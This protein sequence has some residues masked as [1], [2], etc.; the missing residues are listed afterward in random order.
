MTAIELK[1]FVHKF[2]MMNP[3]L[4]ELLSSG[5][6]LEDGMMVLIEDSRERVNITDDFFEKAPRWLLSRALEANRWC[7]VQDAQVIGDNVWFTGVYEDGTKQRRRCEV[8][9]A[10]LVTKVSMPKPAESQEDKYT[11][12]LT[13]VAKTMLAQDAATYH[14]D[15]TGMDKV[16]DEAAKKIMELFA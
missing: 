6:L 4:E 11:Q 9:K 10:W 3:F 12:V 16:A 15:S 13:L 1:Y 5:N 14:G 7:L 8:T 2:H